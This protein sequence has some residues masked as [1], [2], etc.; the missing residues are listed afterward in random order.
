MLRFAALSTRTTDEPRLA[1]LRAATLGKAPGMQDQLI[2]ILAVVSGIVIIVVSTGIAIRTF[3]VPAGA[4]PLINRVL[5]R[6]TQTLFGAVVL[7]PSAPKRAVKM[8]S[9]PG[10][11]RFRCWLSSWF[12]S[13]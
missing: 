2:D 9:Q 7:V 8:C 13:A 10:R 1:A 4:P 3:M 11:A 12:F 5:F 6:F